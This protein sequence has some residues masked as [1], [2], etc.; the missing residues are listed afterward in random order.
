MQKLSFILGHLVREV[1]ALDGL[2]GRICDK[3]AISYRV[4]NAA[5]GPAVLGLRAQID[6]ALYKKNM[7]EVNLVRLSFRT[8]ALLV[9]SFDTCNILSRKFFVIYQ[10]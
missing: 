3:S 2:C 5:A 10:I 1:D 8:G 6:R 4:L 7:Q 9:R